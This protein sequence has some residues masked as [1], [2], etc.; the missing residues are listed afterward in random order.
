M[1]K[2]L[3]VV[4][5]LGSRFLSA[6]AAPGVD[7]DFV[8]TLGQV[9]GVVLV[10]GVKARSGMRVRLSSVIESKSGGRATLLLG[11]GALFH[12]AESTSIQVSEFSAHGNASAT[13]SATL[14]LKVGR[15]R[16][17]VLDRDGSGKKDI[18]IRARSATMGV[19][20]TEV[21]VDVPQ[22]ASEPPTFFTV[23]GST[24]VQVDGQQ[25]PVNLAAN[26]G[27]QVSAPSDSPGS[28]G[29]ST[30]GG[31]QSG[32]KSGQ[33]A[34]TGAQSGAAGASQPSGTVAVTADTIASVV[35]DAGL[36]PPEAPRSAGDTRGLVA[37]NRPDA[38]PQ[39]PAPMVLPPP[40]S[41]TGPV[42]IPTLPPV[43]VDPVAD[44]GSSRVLRVLVQPCGATPGA[45][46]P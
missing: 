1:L 4:T 37:A 14:E 25:A 26:Q 17:L 2:L 16:G 13:Q 22:A 33:A 15:L 42:L 43:F 46:C 27:V 41:F 12:L 31:S 9:K 28:G 20:G 3:L 34:A 23:E 44:G 6:S 21:L 5:L 40:P 10:D 19:R 18:K 8:G 38:R 32:Q 30:G 29:S 35:S 7:E 11:D 36:K 24:V 39:G 45:S